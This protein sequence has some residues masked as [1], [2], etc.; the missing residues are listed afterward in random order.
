MTDQALL[1]ALRNSRLGAELSAEQAGTLVRPPGVSRSRPRRGAG[2][3]RH[4]RQPPLRH[5]PGS[6][7]VVRN[8]GTPAQ[9]T[10]LTLTAGDLVGELSFLDETPHY[11]S[12][13]AVGATRVF[14]LEREELEAL[15]VRPS[16]DRLPRDACDR[17]HRPR[18]P[19]AD[20]H[21]D[22]RAHE[23]HL[24]AAREVLGSGPVGAGSRT[25]AFDAGIRTTVRLRMPWAPWISTPS[26]SAVADGP[27]MKTP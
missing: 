4:L 20:F 1:E 17:A 24:Q 6:L 2:G 26:M 7:G 21:A 22:G 8:A 19:A 14:G 3:R 13:V 25:V 10:L 15:L 18:D 23:L 11:A 27:V 5:R 9:V 16:R 12:L